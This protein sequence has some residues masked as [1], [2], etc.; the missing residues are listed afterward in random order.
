LKDRHLRAARALVVTALMSNSPALADEARGAAAEARFREGRS[1]LADG[2]LREACDKFGES[3][4]LDPAPGTLLNLARCY[5][6]LG[7]TASAWATY[8]KLTQ[9]A[10]EL[11]QT[12]RAEFAT[13]RAA[14][15]EPSLAMLVVRVP[16]AHRIDDLAVEY[17]G[18]PLPVAAWNSRVPIDPGTHH[19]IANAP[20]RLSW[21]RDVDA[22]APRD[23]I[24]EVPL[25][26]E[27]PAMRSTPLHSVGVV[28]TFAGVAAVVTG[29]LF[30][31]VAKMER[32]AAQDGCRSNGVHICRVD[33][34]Q[35]RG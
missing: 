12:A 31:G 35:P 16:S 30:R 23:A 2:K 32:E 22:L 8:R 14:E 33:A 11:G 5:E 27:N 10:T 9:R 13:R 19:I 4:R 26:A 34:A 20:G 17:D 29:L 24:V 6:G 15:L 25:L 28:T 3:E 1:L 18:T 7:R 21:S